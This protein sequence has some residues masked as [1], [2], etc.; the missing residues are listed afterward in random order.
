M[1]RW[2]GLRLDFL[3]TCILIAVTFISIPLVSLTGAVYGRDAGSPY[4]HSHLFPYCLLE[5]K[6]E[7]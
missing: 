6:V 7:Y 1:T 5:V 4:I 2:F 3:S